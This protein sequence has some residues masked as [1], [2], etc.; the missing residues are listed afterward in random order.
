LDAS[1]LVKRY[2]AE[3]ASAM[4]RGAMESADHWFICRVGYVETLRAVSL[5]AGRSAVRAVR[6][7][8]P[9]FGVVEVDQDLVEHAATLALDGELRSLDAL[10]LAAAL[11]L[12][13]DDLVVATWDTR[14]HAAARREGLSVL[15]AVVD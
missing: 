12:P 10:H 3:P 7:E 2:V 1:A 14:L 5:T 4:V 11:V 13:P 8:W 15:P 6:E 9:S